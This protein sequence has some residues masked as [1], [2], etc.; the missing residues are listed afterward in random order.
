MRAVVALWAALALLLVPFTML[1]GAASAHGAT[2]SVAVAADCHAA[3]H[4]GPEAPELPG[5]SVECAL[6]C[7]ALPAAQPELPE[8]AAMTPIAHAFAPLRPFIGATPE[9]D[10]PPP[11][12]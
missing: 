10:D 12:A 6:A 4:D 8:P 9:R 11:R 2:T 7:A 5:R 3:G 1:G